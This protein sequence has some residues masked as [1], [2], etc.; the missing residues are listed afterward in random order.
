MSHSLQ[1]VREREERALSADFFFLLLVLVLEQ[2]QSLSS[3]K[4][5]S[6]LKLCLIVN[7]NFAK[8]CLSFLRHFSEIFA[9]A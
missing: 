7:V 4:H 5:L 1:G 9:F 3:L 2:K 8:S 6:A